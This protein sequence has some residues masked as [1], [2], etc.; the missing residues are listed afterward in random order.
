MRA[1]S[2][3]GIRI[4]RFSMLPAFAFRVS[5]FAFCL[6]RF[7]VSGFDFRRHSHYPVQ[8]VACIRI[9]RFA[10]QSWDFGVWVSGLGFGF[11]CRVSD[12]ENAR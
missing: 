1:E 4:A 3:D 8:H 10:F 5:R 7:E 11:M 6:S 2:S 12:F 9:S